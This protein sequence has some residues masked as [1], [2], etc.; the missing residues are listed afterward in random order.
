MI[1]LSLTIRQVCVIFTL[2]RV[3]R[4]DGVVVPGSPANTALRLRMMT[5]PD[6]A[7]RMQRIVPGAEIEHEQVRSGMGLALLGLALEY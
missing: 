2:V 6:L 4:S 3:R 1:N 7:N 5:N